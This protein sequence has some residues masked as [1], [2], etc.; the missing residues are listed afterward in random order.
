MTFSI[1][2]GTQKKQPAKYE[3]LSITSSKETFL[4]E[5]NYTV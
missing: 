1:N 5:K 2:F 3:N 4:Q